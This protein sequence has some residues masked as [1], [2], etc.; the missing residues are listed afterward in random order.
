[1][2]KD[3]KE[4]KIQP[5]IELRSREVQELM[6]NIPSGILQH[7]IG[8]ILLILIGFIIISRFITYQEEQY[9]M[10]NIQPNTESIS[11]IATMDGKILHNFIKKRTHTLLGDTLLEFSSGDSTFY[12]CA[13]TNGQIQMKS[14]CYE[15]ENISK[16]QILF[17]ITKEARKNSKVFAIVNLTESNK[18]N[19]PEEL[20]VDLNQKDLTFSLQDKLTDA[21][22]NT[23]D[24]L[25][26]ADKNLSIS[27]PILI[28][29]RTIGKRISLF[30]KIFGQ[31]LFKKPI[32]TKE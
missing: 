32:I 13:E 8:F 10:L 26:L 3:I 11:V 4:V 18:E 15:G 25:Y 29:G 20:L 12:I 24:F 31:Q 28:E 16:N 1:M 7:G 21:T 17:E 27:H 5:H 2:K 6:G 23:S 22:K 19:V 14:F 9:I 30:K